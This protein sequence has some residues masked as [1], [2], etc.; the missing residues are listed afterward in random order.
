MRTRAHPDSVQQAIL[1]QIFTIA[2][3]LT[4]EEKASRRNIEAVL[5]GN[6]KPGKHAADAAHV[7]EAAKYCGY[8]I[9]HDA[10]ILKRAAPFCELPQSLSIVTLARFL[11]IFDEYEVAALRRTQSVVAGDE[12]DSQVSLRPNPD[13]GSWLAEKTAEKARAVEDIRSALSLVKGNGRAPDSW[14]QECSVEAIGALFR[15]LYSLALVNAQIALTPSDQRC[16]VGI[17]QDRVT[18]Y[19]VPL[20]SR[21]FA[22]AAAEPVRQSGHFGPILFAGASK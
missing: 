5:Q 21:A 11:E 10:Q 2:T 4:Y 14:E 15:G 9:T 22:I 13:K 12:M 1:P 6:A 20:L 18:Q 3:G 17:A 16:M 19:D 7:F 8:F